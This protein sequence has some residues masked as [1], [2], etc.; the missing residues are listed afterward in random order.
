MERSLRNAIAMA[1][2]VV[3]LK[4]VT[5]KEHY[6]DD[7]CHHLM[8]CANLIIVLNKIDKIANKNQLLT[9]IASLDAAYHPR[10]IVPVS[11][12]CMRPL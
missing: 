10:A 5:A 4:D 6:D 1:H 8:G 3:W 7:L 2:A 12:A 9:L 11:S